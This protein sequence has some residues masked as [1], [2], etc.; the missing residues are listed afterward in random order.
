MV[1]PAT[2]RYREGGRRGGKTFERIGENGEY[3]IPAAFVMEIA[4][5]KGAP[6]AAVHFEVR[7]GRPEC[8]E[9][10]I[11]AQS[12]GRAI[13][14]SDVGVFANLGQVIDVAVA[15]NARKVY[16]DEETGTRWRSPRDEAETWAARRA[17]NDRRT[18]PRTN[19]PEELAEVARIYREHIDGAPLDAIRHLMGYGSHRTAARRVENARKA[20]LLPETEQG[21]RKA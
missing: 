8:V 10:T 20:G 13:R 18:Q 1:W 2:T 21:K 4:G 14:S 16:P 11:R 19:S 3:M 5:N 12:N 7:D 9:I 17:V 6:D 15:E